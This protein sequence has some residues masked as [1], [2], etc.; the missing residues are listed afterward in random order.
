MIG[1]QAIVAEARTWLGVRWHHQ[2]RDRGGIDCGGLVVVVARALGISDYDIAG[3][4][5]EP[6]TQTD[7]LSHFERNMRRI[8]QPYPGSVGVFR[9]ETTVIHCGIFSSKYG[10]VHLIEANAA[11]RK[12]VESALPKEQGALLVGVFDFPGVE[13]WDR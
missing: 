6:P 12:V 2:G 4:R 7:F 11:C 9:H 1:R 8:T 3:Y 13:P 10:S 5:R